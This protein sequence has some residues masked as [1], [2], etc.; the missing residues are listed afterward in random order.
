MP[1]R[2]E[3]GFDDVDFDKIGIHVHVPGRSVKD[4]PSAGITI[5][6]ALIRRSGRA[7]DHQTMT[8]NPALRS[9]PGGGLRESAGGASRRAQTIL[10]PK[11][12]DLFMVEV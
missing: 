12:N 4:G 7:V 2:A 10:V 1:A 9:C 11:Q 6:T 3:N 5:A 8:A